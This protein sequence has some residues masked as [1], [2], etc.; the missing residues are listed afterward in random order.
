MWVISRRYGFASVGVE[1]LSLPKLCLSQTVISAEVRYATTSGQ[2]GYVLFTDTD[3][4][5]F[6]L[7]DIEHQSW[8][9]LKVRFSC[10]TKSG[11]IHSPYFAGV[12][13]I[14][15]K[16][17]DMFIHVF[18]KIGFYLAIKCRLFDR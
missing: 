13:D 12:I 14:A 2:R 10:H 4:T 6:A 11:V 5:K 8:M 17:C 7:S 16:S 1:V 18:W 9:K 3:L 15:G